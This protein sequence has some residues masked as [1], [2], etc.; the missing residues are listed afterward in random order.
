MKFQMFAEEKSHELTQKI[1]PSLPGEFGS[2]NLQR[3]ASRWSPLLQL[4][5]AR[6]EKKI[7]M[8]KESRNLDVNGIYPLV[9]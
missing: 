6:E 7:L 9:I 3:L 8:Q 1:Q 5:P 4:P 2:W